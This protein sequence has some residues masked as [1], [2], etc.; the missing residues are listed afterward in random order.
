MLAGRVPIL[1]EGPVGH[2]TGGASREI[3]QACIAMK[4]DGAD[5]FCPGITDTFRLGEKEDRIGKRLR[6]QNLN[7]NRRQEQQDYHRIRL[8]DYSVCF[9]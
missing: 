3:V 4:S 1:D 5:A 6:I 8:N 2:S 9:L 7:E